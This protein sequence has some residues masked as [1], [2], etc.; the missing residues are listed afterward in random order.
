MLP[1]DIQAHRLS[2]VEQFQ[3]QIV[4]NI[5]KLIEWEKSHPPSSFEYKCERKSPVK[6]LKKENDVS[7]NADKKDVLETSSDEE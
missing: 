1:T 4:M 6:K 5:L 2:P 7:K 3:G